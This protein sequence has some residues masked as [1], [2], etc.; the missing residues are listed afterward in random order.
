M[1]GVTIPIDDAFEVGGERLFLPSGPS[2]S[3][4][5]TANCR[6]YVAYGVGDMTDR[7]EALRHETPQEEAAR[8]FRGD[9]EFIYDAEGG[10]WINGY[11]PRRDGKP[12]ENSGVTIGAGVDLGHQTEAGLRA[13]NVDREVL[14]KVKPYLG[15]IR[16]DADQYLKRNPLTLSRE[17]AV[18]L[19][20]RVHDGIIGDMARR[21]N[22]ASEFDFYD[23]PSDAQTVIA[24]VA[25][26]YGPDMKKKTPKFW[27]FVTDGEWDKGSRRT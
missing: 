19:T 17:D 1:E 20:D 14:E 27:R 13:L 25:I 21:Y 16:E 12:A 15:R 6:C 5:E 2:A 10:L 23:L 18:G 7:E 4:E 9:R 11:V 26:Q 22:R 24:D 3:L 8:R